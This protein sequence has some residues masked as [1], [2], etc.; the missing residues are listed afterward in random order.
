MNDQ[1]LFS[2]IINK[3]EAVM[4]PHIWGEC[5]EINSTVAKFLKEKG[6]NI[7]CVAG[8]VNCDR[9]D[10]IDFVTDSQHFWLKYNGKILDFASQQ[11]KNS[12]LDEELNNSMSP[13]FFGY[14]EQYVEISSFPIENE[15]IKT[16]Y[17]DWLNPKH[18]D[19][20]KYGE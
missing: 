3:V 18:N 1:E 17:K 15:W 7:E 20:I 5:N 2:L 13:Y 16:Y 11:F 6:F 4:N 10:S 9:P 14:S 12:F 8:Y 19:F